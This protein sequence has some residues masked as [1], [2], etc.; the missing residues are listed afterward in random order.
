MLSKNSKEK[1]K[2][3][4]QTNL[5]SR[6]ALLCRNLSFF[7]RIHEARVDEL[8]FHPPPLKLVVNKSSAVLIFVRELDDL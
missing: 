5:R 8:I 3:Y 7:R 6:L 1:K 4:E 2:V